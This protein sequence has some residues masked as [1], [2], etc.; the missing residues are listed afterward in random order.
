MRRLKR[1]IK[2]EELHLCKGLR[3]YD[4]EW[5]SLCVDTAIVLNWPSF[6]CFGCKQEGPVL[7]CLATALVKERKKQQGMDF[8]SAQREVVEEML[9]RRWPGGWPGGD[10]DCGHSTCTLELMCYNPAIT[11]YGLTGRR[12]KQDDRL[13][14]GKG[15]RK[16]KERKIQRQPVS[17]GGGEEGDGCVGLEAGGELIASGEAGA[18]GDHSGG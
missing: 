7:W 11:V 15:G 3:E 10:K 2:L 1:E 8:N 4:C 18:T 9:R 17:A 5:Y 6:A 12:I 14:K 13:Y 16:R